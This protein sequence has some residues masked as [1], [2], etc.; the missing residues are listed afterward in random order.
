MCIF[1]CLSS[2]SQLLWPSYNVVSIASSSSHS[3]YYTWVWHP[4][5]NPKYHLSSLEKSINRNL[6]INRYYTCINSAFASSGGRHITLFTHIDFILGKSPSSFIQE[7]LKLPLSQHAQY[8]W[9]FDCACMNT[10][11]PLKKKMKYSWIQGQLSE[12]QLVKQLHKKRLFDVSRREVPND[13]H[14]DSVLLNMFINNWSEDAEMRQICCLTG[15]I[16]LRIRGNILDNR[17]RI[18]RTS[19]GWLRE[20]NFTWIIIHLSISSFCNSH[21][22]PV[23]CQTL[24]Q[25]LRIQWIK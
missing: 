24:L 11:S 8:I 19:T 1:S 16:K 6:C 9:I 10:F 12:W 2:L 20:I 4:Q 17:I 5:Q 7:V 21:C 13:T 3:F 25:V 15:D 14:Q 22:I 23:P 18:Q